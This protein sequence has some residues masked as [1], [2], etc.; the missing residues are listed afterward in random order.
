VEVRLPDEG[1]SARTQASASGQAGQG[2]FAVSGQQVCG[3]AWCL[4]SGAEPRSAHLY[5]MWVDPAARGKGVGRALLAEAI[6][7]A[8]SKGAD[9]VRLGVTVAESPAMRL[10]ESHGFYPVGDAQPLREGS[11]L[12]V[13]DMVLD[14]GTGM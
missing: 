13:Q 14:L 1:W 5:Q 8:R 3:L 4:L 10:Y 12:W 2:F 11:P 9:H 6:A 7:W